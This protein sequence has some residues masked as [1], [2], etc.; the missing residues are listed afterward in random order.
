MRNDSN[1]NSLAAVESLAEAEPD[2]P[3][4]QASLY[5]VGNEVMSFVVY[6]NVAYLSIYIH[7]YVY[8]YTYFRLSLSLS[9]C[10]HG[11]T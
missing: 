4:K 1:G 6:S 3:R 7:V 11:I 8:V 2:N 5:R 10:M 9:L